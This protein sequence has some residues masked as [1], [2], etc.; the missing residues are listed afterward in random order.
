MRVDRP[1]Q[2]GPA[3]CVVLRLGPPAAQT[4]PVR[5]ADLLDR[6]GL[7]YGDAVTVDVARADLAPTELGLLLGAL[8]RRVGPRGQVVLAG[9]SEAASRGWD[10]LGLTPSASGRSCSGPP[11]PRTPSRCRRSARPAGSRAEPCGAATAAR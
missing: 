9:A 5:L 10:R 8:W 11:R 2:A 7:R 4:F 3:R 6:A 1:E